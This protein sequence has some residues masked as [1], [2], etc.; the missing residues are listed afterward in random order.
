MSKNCPY[1]GRELR[2]IGGY[3]HPI[4]EECEC[5]R[6]AREERQRESERRC[7]E[8]AAQQA[9]CRHEWQTA[10]MDGVAFDRCPKCGATRPCGG[11][12]SWT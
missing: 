7:R 3:Y 8:I 6:R 5:E 11:R 1:C 4:Y 10:V 9:A 12:K 2:I